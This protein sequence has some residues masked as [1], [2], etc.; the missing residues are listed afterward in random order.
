MSNSQQQATP[1]QN[2]TKKI[3]GI[4]LNV[5]LWIFL[6][7]AFVMVVFAFSSTSNEY[8]V[9]I[10]GKKVILTVQSDS[11]K[12]VFKSGDLLV[13]K[14]L[15]DEEKAQLKEGDIVTFFVDLN[16][17]GVKE[18]NTHRIVSVNNGVFKT[19]GDNN[20][21]NDSYDVYARDI[22]A[23]WKEGDTKIGGL[24]GFI[25]FLQ[26]STGFLI[27][28]VIPLAA[29]FVYEVVK[30]ILTILK[31]KNKDKKTITASDE[32]E[33]K[34]KAIEE[35]LKS[36]GMAVPNEAPKAEE[37]KPAEEAEVPAEATAEEAEP[38]EAAPEAEETPAEEGEE[39]KE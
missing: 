38:A 26:S 13:A 19:K 10:L 27:V 30:L 1:Q 9:P 2:K 5:L 3:V 7:F 33:I 23:T 32:E 20:A 37:A 25:S 15:T 4:V 16:N 22:V 28:I 31:L 12:P 36:Q 14:V 24:G 17:D 34:R 8:R 29:F 35:Y 39:K 6:V 21:I 18:L 11:M